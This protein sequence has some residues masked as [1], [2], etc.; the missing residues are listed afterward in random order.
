MGYRSTVGLYAGVELRL[1]VMFSIAAGIFTL[2]L[3]L[4]ALCFRLWRG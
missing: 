2:S 1:T 4:I 3:V